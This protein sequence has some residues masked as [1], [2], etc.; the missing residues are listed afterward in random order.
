MRS[1]DNVSITAAKPRVSV[2]VPV[3]NGED[4]IAAALDSLLAQTYTDFELI[5]SDNCSTDRTA[6]ICAEYARTD[7]RVR[8]YRVEENQGASWNFSRV[9]E[10]ARGEYFR[11]AAHD[12]LVAPTYL[13][14]CVEALDSNPDAVW[15]H[16]QSFEIGEHGQ[17]LLDDQPIISYIQ[18]DPSRISPQ[19]HQR[20]RSV[21]LGGDGVLD[22]YGLVRT[23]AMRRTG[24]NRPYY[25]ADRVFVSELCLMG[26]YVEVP[27]PLFM[28]RC[29]AKQSIW[30]DSQKAQEEWIDPKTPKRLPLPRQLRCAFGNLMLI[31]AARLSLMEKLRCTLV[32]LRFVVN[33]GKIKRLAVDTL[34]ALGL[35]V[36]VP[37]DAKRMA[38]QAAA[39]R[40]LD[41]ANS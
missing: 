34:R 5:I 22:F 29:H 20:F 6:E 36:A 9:F 31:P 37:E 28:Y 3:Y 19:A 35:Q 8:F 27:E 30:L 18:S 12:D 17:P 7:P 26:P 10:L 38:S 1:T 15:S 16:T 14:R 25:G 32:W 2:G 33:A 11:W 13:E 4:F 21:L 24:L 39:Q 40:S 41:H 23:A